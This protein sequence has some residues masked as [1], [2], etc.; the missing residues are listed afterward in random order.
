MSQLDLLRGAYCPLNA[1]NGE[2]IAVL[3]A[4]FDKLAH[5]PLRVAVINGSGR[6]FQT[7]RANQRLRAA[8]DLEQCR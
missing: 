3:L 8:L 5:E 7:G 6:N 4:A 2:M 1:Y